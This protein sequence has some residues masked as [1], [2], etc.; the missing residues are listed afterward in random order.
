MKCIQANGGLKV[1][2]GVKASGIV[3]TNHNRVALRVKVGVKV[4]GFS[5]QHNRRAF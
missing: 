4:G 1:K 2:A 5:A 3:P